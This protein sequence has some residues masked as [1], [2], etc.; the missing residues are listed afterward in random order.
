MNSAGAVYII[1]ADRAV[2]E[3]RAR[4]FA[5][6]NLKP[7]IH[8]SPLEFL[9]S[10]TPDK[11]CCLVSAMRMPELPGLE[12]LARL[13][14]HSQPPPVIMITAHGDVKS[15]VQA[16]KL[17]AA[18]FLETPI[19][20]ERLLRLVQHW[21]N[22]DRIERANFRKCAAVREKLAKLSAREREVLAG[23]L[24]GLSNKEMA[25]RLEV[26]PKSIEVYRGK[27]MAKMEASSIPGL[28]REALCCPARNC[29]P[30]GYNCLSGHAICH[31]N[32]SPTITDFEANMEI[33]F[34]LIDHRKAKQDINTFRFSPMNIGIHPELD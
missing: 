32:A 18:E 28:V 29:N 1:D 30:A 12:L 13:Q 22:A 20:E 24:D 5:S 23:I 14:K 31:S 33:Q 19:H 21:I 2:A 4:L 10:F 8:H 17:G 16:M 3:A 27:L 15:A 25:R 7:R 9:R 11:P 26:S 6:V 34:S